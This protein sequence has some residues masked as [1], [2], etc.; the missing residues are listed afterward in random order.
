MEGNATFNDYHIN[1][2]LRLAK[3][4]VGFNENKWIQQDSKPP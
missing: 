1:V 2:I 3:V 4:L